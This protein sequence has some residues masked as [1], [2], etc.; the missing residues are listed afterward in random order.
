MRRVISSITGLTSMFLVMF[1]FIT[2]MCDTADL[3][4]QLQ[5]VCM[6]VAIIA[7]GT[8]LGFIAKEVSNVHTR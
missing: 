2:C 6:G 4:K 1:G 7:I 3:D 5:T 8:V